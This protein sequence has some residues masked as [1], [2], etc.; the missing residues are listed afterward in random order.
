LPLF[1]AADFVPQLRFGPAMF[2]TPASLLQRIRQAPEKE[3]WEHFVR[4]YTPLLM[5]WAQRLGLQEPDAADLV[6]DV[7][8][9]MLRKL[10]EFQ[11][12]PG[13]SFRGWLRTVLRNTWRNRLK[14]RT[15]ASL[16]HAVEPEALPEYS[17]LEQREYQVY[18][19]QRAMSLMVSD[20]KPTTWK[21]CWETVV[22]GRPATEVA[23][24]LGI[25][26]NAV[27][28]AKSRVLARL[29][30]DLDGLLE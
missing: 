29:R 11:Y 2:K 15:P 4:L 25:T 17:G 27:Y 28:L 7:L 8:V 13:R 5:D 12:Q 20:F 21:A 19:V 6:Q 3:A 18:I 22:G 14:T 26:V 24:E 30:E 9:V 16:D 10:P 1:V 23:A